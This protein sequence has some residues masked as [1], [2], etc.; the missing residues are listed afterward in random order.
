MAINKYPYTD[1]NEYNLD[2]IIRKLMQLEKRENVKAFIVNIADFVPVLNDGTFAEAV[3]KALDVSSYIYVPKGEYRVNVSITRDC[4]IFFDDEAVV[5]STQDAPAFSFSN[6]SPSIYNGKC[7]EGD[8]DFDA[9]TTEEKELKWAYAHGVTKEGRGIF[10][11]HGCHDI[12]VEG[13]ECHHSKFPAILYFKDCHNIEVARCDFQY[14]LTAGIF[15]VKYNRN[16]N[17]H[18]CSFRHIYPRYAQ[19][20]DRGHETWCYAVVTGGL[21]LSG[22]ELPPDNMHVHNCYVEDSYDCGIDTH[23][24]TNVCFE[25]NKIIN[26]RTSLTAYNDNGRVERPDGW[27]MENIIMR[28][29]YCK[30]D[31]TVLTE[32]WI[33][34]FVYLGSANPSDVNSN[35]KHGG[36]HTYQNLIFENNYLESPNWH[37]DNQASLV[38][39]HN[40]V[41]NARFANNYL[42]G[43]DGVRRAYT[44]YHCFDVELVN[45][46][47][48]DF[49][50]IP[51]LV[52][53]GTLVEHGNKTNNGKA[54]FD[55]INYMF[56]YIRGANEEDNA[57][58][59]PYYTG[60]LHAFGDI[61][62]D[63][64]T[65]T[66]ITTSYGRRVIT[67]KT[68][69]AAAEQ[70][71]VTVDDGI[72][73]YTGII[74]L[75][76]GQC[77]TLTAGGSPVN[78]VV[79][80]LIDTHH[81]I[82]KTLA[83]WSDPSDD[84]YTLDVLTETRVQLD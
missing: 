31:K 52:M 55:I 5:T 69:A 70:F 10:E 37:I 67:G 18:N 73:E 38:Y 24:A 75:V 83:S 77:V 43:V 46:R 4:S 56:S 32:G 80:D 35:G 42:K 20:P 11:F 71:S 76:P 6:C 16:M 84:T 74:P 25:N 68:V 34:P 66:Y 28:N 49:D 7:Y 51:V 44:F 60:M 26:C 23:G 82:L 13:L 3:E 36:L 54:I 50:N 65:N 53:H 61:M 41:W 62:K 30:S 2:W 45:N 81:M 33:H 72:A 8:D 9:T 59:G 48:E 12:H 1:F 64:D 27:V 17:V 58:T 78:Y 39:T 57:I 21:S 22:K 15:F 79:A 29:N 14:M 47:M 40:G 19:D 63:T